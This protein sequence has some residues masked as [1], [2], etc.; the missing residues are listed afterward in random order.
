MGTVLNALEANGLADNTLVICTTDHGLPF[1]GA[2]ATLYDRGLGV[3]L[4][5]RGPGGINGGVA[6]DALVSH[7]DVFPT[8]M[9]LIGAER[10]DYLQGESL[11]PLVIGEQDEVR[12]TIFGEKTYHVAYEPERSARTH[13]YKY[14]RRFD[15][16]HPNPVLANID[17]GPSKDVILE[18][19]WADHAIPEERLF[20]LLHDPQEMHNVACEPDHADAIADMRDRLRRWM[21]ETRDPLLKGPVPAPKGAVLNTPDQ[22]SPREPT[23]TV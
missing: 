17:D 18:N 13:R 22:T 10:P 15:K 9:D 7:I 4:I 6:I 11:L 12:E 23:I 1:P 2:K 16:S 20:D 19:G 3:M 5:M 8:I 21:V 14:I